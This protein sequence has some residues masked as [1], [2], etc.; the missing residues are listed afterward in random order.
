MYG[1]TNLT[2]DGKKFDVTKDFPRRKD[3][4]KP[5]SSEDG[6]SLKKGDEKKLRADYFLVMNEETFID[7][8]KVS[9]TVTVRWDGK[10]WRVTEISGNSE[11]ARVKMKEF[12]E[13]Y[14]IALQETD[15]NVPSAAERLRSK[16]DWIPS[17]AEIDFYSDIF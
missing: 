10:R 6:V 11:I 13:D 15:G 4:P 5:L 2:I 14:K 9:E 16:Y 7:A 1:I 17:K 3:K 12:W 8:Q